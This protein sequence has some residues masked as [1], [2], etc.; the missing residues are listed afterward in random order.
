MTWRDHKKP[1][2]LVKAHFDQEPVG[3]TCAPF[4]SRHRASLSDVDAVEEQDGSPNCRS[5]I[6]FRQTVWASSMVKGMGICEVV[7]VASYQD[8][9]P[10]SHSIVPGGF[11][12][13][14]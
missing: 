5:Q 10:Y 9:L 1:I 7:I 13:T 12:V 2:R 4:V 6:R 8:A 14:S 3:R 11:D